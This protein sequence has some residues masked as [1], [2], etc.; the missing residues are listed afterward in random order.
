MFTFHKSDALTR[1]RQSSVD[2]PVF[3][4]STPPTTSDAWGSQYFEASHSQ[5]MHSPEQRRRAQ[6]AKRNSVFT[7]RSRSNTA[8]SIASSVPPSPRSTADGAP[9]A[10]FPFQGASQSYF[11]HHGQKRSMFRGKMGKR[12]SDSLGP[13]PASDENQDDAGK[14]R[15]SFL[16]NRR[17]GS[18]ADDACK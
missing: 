2:S 1:S 12:L 7:L 9:E 15:S 10:S 6:P 18:E 3:E 4:I 13:G 17:K 16:R 11:E 5:D 14:K 8:T